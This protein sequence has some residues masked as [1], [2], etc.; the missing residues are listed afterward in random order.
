[1][2]QIDENEE[3]KGEER[4]H[5]QLRNKEILLAQIEEKQ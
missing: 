3:I 1:M 2:D 4:K 5:I